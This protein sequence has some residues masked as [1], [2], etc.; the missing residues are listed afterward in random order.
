MNSAAPSSLFQD[1][2]RQGGHF[3]A[4]FP[5]GSG[6][7]EDAY[8]IRGYKSSGRRGGARKTPFSDAGRLLG[9]G[10]TPGGEGATGAASRGRF[11]GGA[12][13]GPG[14]VFR[15][16]QNFCLADAFP[17]T[18]K[19]A[20]LESDQ[21]CRKQNTT[22]PLISGPHERSPRRHPLPSE[23]KEHAARPPRRRPGGFRL[24]PIRCKNC[25]KFL[26]LLCRPNNM[27]PLA[28]HLFSVRPPFAR[29]TTVEEDD[30]G[31]T[32]DGRRRSADGE[33]EL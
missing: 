23:T 25:A 29:R 8:S 24:P 26:R 16:A 27:S 30:D 6:G 33:K 13:E 14:G 31:R 21:I 20:G 17:C 3:L 22:D 28:S 5:R 9:S 18:T 32:D 19:A 7:R 11:R 15:E 10:R 2:P 12:R 1:C 4:G